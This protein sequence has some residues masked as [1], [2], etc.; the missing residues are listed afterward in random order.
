MQIKTAAH[1]LVKLINLYPLK[2]GTI[3]N[4]KRNKNRLLNVDQNLQQNHRVA[5]II[6][7]WNVINC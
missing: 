1:T 4:L 7:P 3:E 2:N 6:Y 5:L